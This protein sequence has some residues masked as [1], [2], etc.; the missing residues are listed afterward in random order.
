M[1]GG[2]NLMGDRMEKASWTTL[3]GQRAM[4]RNWR[5]M[6]SWKI[7]EVA[8][9]KSLQADTLRGV[10]HDRPQH[11]LVGRK[12]FGRT[13][14]AQEK[15]QLV[16]LVGRSPQARP[17]VAQRDVRSKA[18]S[19][20]SVRTKRHNRPG[21]DECPTSLRAGRFRAVLG[22][23]RRRGTGCSAP[24]RTGC[25][26]VMSRARYRFS[27]L[28]NTFH[29]AASV[30]GAGNFSGRFFLSQASRTTCMS[31]AVTLWFVRVRIRSIISASGSIA[32]V[33][34]RATVVTLTPKDAATSLRHF[35]LAARQAR[36][37]R[38]VCMTAKV[39]SNA[40]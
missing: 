31:S 39:A 37:V 40:T 19:A 6:E 20:D 21:A 38:V 24:S 23:L 30:T 26:S 7:G 3:P 22:G 27:T 15:R 2:Q 28:Q 13:D 16:G 11:G 35:E 33:S 8:R 29:S 10:E 32:P 25:L 5:T 1:C 12:P 17:G 4:A 18:R 34:H 9:G 36:K 14:Q